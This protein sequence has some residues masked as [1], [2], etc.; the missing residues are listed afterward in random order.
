MFRKKM[1][2]A[3]AAP[4]AAVAGGIV[5]DLKR[6]SKRLEF[7]SHRVSRPDRSRRRGSASSLTLD[8]HERRWFL[9]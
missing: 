2:L 6:M 3:L 4:V 1:M 8:H 5:V 9:V 7:I